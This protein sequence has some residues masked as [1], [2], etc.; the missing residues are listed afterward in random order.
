[1]LIYFHRSEQWHKQKAIEIT[2]SLEHNTHSRPG[3]TQLR[4]EKR[5]HS[6][7]SHAVFSQHQRHALSQEIGRLQAERAAFKVLIDESQARFTVLQG[8]KVSAPAVEGQ[9]RRRSTMPADQ[10][11]AFDTQL[12]A[13]VQA[14][15]RWRAI[16]Q[17]LLAAIDSSKDKMPDVGD[18]P[19]V[20]N[21]AQLVRKLEQ[22]KS[23]RFSS[24]AR[25]SIT[26]GLNAIPHLSGI[27]SDTTTQQNSEG[28]ASVD[29]STSLP[30]QHETPLLPDAFYNPEPSGSLQDFDLAA[31]EALQSPWNLPQSLSG[32]G[33][34]WDAQTGE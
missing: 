7:R 6:R 26:I 19:L 12:A 28:A 21:E 9:R 24:S 5:S 34:L 23:G 29:F 31:F 18:I 16:R 3:I 33:G 14:R 22:G 13:E 10:R 8:R 17:K 2:T 11:Q 32:L 1:L 25:L 30:L 4:R 15:D 27:D 20:D